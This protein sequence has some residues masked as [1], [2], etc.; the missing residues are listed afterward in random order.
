MQHNS[1]ES[2]ADALL[3][4]VTMAVLAIIGGV[5]VILLTFLR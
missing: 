5:G 1:R 2:W 3:W 4:G